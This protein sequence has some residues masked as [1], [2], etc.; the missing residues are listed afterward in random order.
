MTLSQKAIRSSKRK[1]VDELLNKEQYTKAWWDTVKLITNNL[2]KVGL[3]KEF[4][5]IDSVRQNNE[6][7]ATNLNNY[8]KSVG[9]EA[10]QSTADSDYERSTDYVL[11]QPISIR[12]K[13]PTEQ[14]RHH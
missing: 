11:L 14:S 9:G 2:K 3:T 1:F 7:L 12:G 5:V 10:L 4:S 6:L 13:T 8:F